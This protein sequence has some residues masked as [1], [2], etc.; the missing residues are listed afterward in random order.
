MA[1]SRSTTTT[2]PQARR[3]R[4]PKISRDQI[5]DSAV[6]LGL[7]SFTM[8]G[9][10]EEL[11]VSPATL[12]SHVAGRQEVVGLVES[13]LHTTMRGFATDATDWRSWL[14]DFAALVRAELGSSASTL[15]SASRDDA[16]MRIDVGE[17]GLRLLMD[18]GFSSVEAAYAVWLVVRVAVT[19]SSGPEPSFARYLGPTASLVDAAADGSEFDAL[20]RV[21]DDLTN[22]D[23]HDTFEF[24]LEVLLDG[25]AARL[26]RTTGNSDHRSG[27]TGD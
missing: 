25:I 15:L 12:Y 17:P 6:R 4:P 20:R 8:Q 14:I 23:G 16:R 27:A 1:D 13:R 7:D 19:A 22:S 3:G 11:D 2:P 9:L 24:D 10:A 26:A 5:V 21:H 18:A